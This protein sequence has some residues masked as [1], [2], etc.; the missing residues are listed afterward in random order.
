MI[1]IKWLEKESGAIF[2]KKLIKN[3]IFIIL[4]FFFRLSVMTV[5]SRYVKQL[6]K[7]SLRFID[8]SNLFLMITAVCAVMELLGIE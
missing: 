5:Y 2:L 7:K 6:N 4:V 3:A 1:I 8:I